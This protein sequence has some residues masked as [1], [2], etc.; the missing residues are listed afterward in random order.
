MEMTHFPGVPTQSLL[1]LTARVA[2]IFMLIDYYILLTQISQKGCLLQQ[3]L[4]AGLF[5]TSQYYGLVLGLWS[6]HP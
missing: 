3:D 5:E 6:D 2:L 4:L 1:F